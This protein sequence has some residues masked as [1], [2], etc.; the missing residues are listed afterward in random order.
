MARR[1]AGKVTHVPVSKEWTRLVV[2]ATVLA[3]RRDGGAAHWGVA[4][5][6]TTRAAVVPDALV[7]GSPARA[8][9]GTSGSTSSTISRQRPVLDRE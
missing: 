7:S 5:S 4:H 8:Q 2:P 6:T 9:L 1:V 3:A